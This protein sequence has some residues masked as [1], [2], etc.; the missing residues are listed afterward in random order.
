MSVEAPWMS[1]L[2]E[3]CVVVGRGI[4]LCIDPITLSLYTLPLN[5]EEKAEMN[6]IL[7]QVC[8][9]VFIHTYVLNNK[10]F[11][12]K[13]SWCILWLYCSWTIRFWLLELFSE[14]LDSWFSSPVVSGPG[15]VLR[16]PA[17]ADRHP[18][19]PRTA[20][21]HCLLPAAGPRAP[22]PARSQ[23]WHHHCPQGLQTCM[24]G[25]SNCLNCITQERLMW[26]INPDRVPSIDVSEEC[27]VDFPLYSHGW[28]RLPL[29]VRRQ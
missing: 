10:A 14:S 13:E 7:L 27:F 22:H 1:S 4:L 23:W 6:Q 21:P 25:S 26:R 11:I 28:R 19:Q 12:C 8:V 16:F 5:L 29:P 24:F 20:P 15:S 3:S 2:E 9:C 17:S 18:A